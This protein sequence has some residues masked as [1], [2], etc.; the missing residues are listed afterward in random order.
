M[1]PHKDIKALPNKIR[2]N[3]DERLELTYSIDQTR[4]N[5][6]HPNFYDN[7]SHE[8]VLRIRF[9]N[10]GNWL[11][12]ATYYSNILLYDRE[13]MP[14]TANFDY[15]FYNNSRLIYYSSENVY[16]I[17]YTNSHAFISCKTN[18]NQGEI[19]TFRVEDLIY[20]IGTIVKFVANI[21]YV[22]NGLIEINNNTYST[23]VFE[24][25]KNNFECT[26]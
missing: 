9:R 23:R 18:L 25:E 11:I 15:K 21:P 19:E 13:I 10:S 5:F 6:T 22:R 2:L 7:T 20:I 1:I 24:G 12:A 16:S 3:Y 4:N 8:V 17:N 14:F 26:T